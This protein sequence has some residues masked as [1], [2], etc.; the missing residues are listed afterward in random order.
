VHSIKIY[1][2]AP[3]LSGRYVVEFLNLFYMYGPLHSTLI[4][5]TIPT[6]PKASPPP[7]KLVK[8]NGDSL[9]NREQLVLG[10]VR[11]TELVAELDYHCSLYVTLSRVV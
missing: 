2:I 4:P 9:R 11:G 1:G 6:L 7:R 3:T 5:I 10:I 8:R